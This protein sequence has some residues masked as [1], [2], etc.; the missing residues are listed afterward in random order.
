MALAPFGP[1]VSERI[2]CDYFSG[3]WSL[4]HCSGFR[5][6]LSSSLSP[7]QTR[8]TGRNSRSPSV[9][10]PCPA[11]EFFLCRIRAEPECGTPG[12][13]RSV[14]FQITL[15]REQLLAVECKRHSQLD[16]SKMSSAFRKRGTSNLG[17]CCSLS[18]A[19]SMRSLEQQAGG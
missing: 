2:F 11:V 6:R 15:L 16:P 9:H 19:R 14:C 12:V 7:G 10:A 5:G 13:N 18:S 4:F 1:H 3:T 17:G 8:K